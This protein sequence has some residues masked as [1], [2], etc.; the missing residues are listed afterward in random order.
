MTQRG[1]SPDKAKLSAF[2]KQIQRGESPSKAELPA[3][4]GRKHGECDH[5]DQ[6]AAVLVDSR[7]R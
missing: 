4:G 1:E 5:E 6:P 7:R 3:F 2:G